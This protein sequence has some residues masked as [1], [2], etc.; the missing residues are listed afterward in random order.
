MANNPILHPATRQRLVRLCGM[1]GSEHDG[2]RAN[3]ARLADR[4]IRET[5]LT[6]EGVI[7]APPVAQPEARPRPA[8][9]AGAP[10]WTASGTVSGEAH[11]ILQRHRA[12]LTQWEIEFLA[13]LLNRR[14]LTEP[15][16][17]SFDRIKAKLQARGAA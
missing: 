1:L 12:L 14:T 15:Q 11:A 17:A 8:Q 10:W 2:E 3:A 4:L 9:P 5:G 6:W 16:R 7:A 13:N